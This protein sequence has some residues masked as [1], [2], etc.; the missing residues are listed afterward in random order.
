MT[1][2]HWSQEDRHQFIE[3]LNVRLPTKRL[4]SQGVLR[5]DRDQVLLCQLTYK[6]EW[7]LPGGV[8]DQGESPAACVGRECREE[9][10]VDLR[11]GRLLTTSWLPPYRGWDDAVLFLFD[12]GRVD[13]AWLQT[14]T[15]QTREIVA[16]HWCDPD[17]LG[18]YAAPYTVR[19]LTQ[20]IATPPQPY[21]EN[22][23]PRP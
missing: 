9:L 10:G 14:L 6:L 20:A 22:G 3:R 19:A 4:I 21:L 17:E 5:N 15:L 12:L 18:T 1:R 7:D 8:V 11:V 16:A 2:Q 13:P 23:E